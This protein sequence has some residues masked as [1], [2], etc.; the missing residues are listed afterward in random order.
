MFLEQG[1][2][3]SIVQEPVIVIFQLIQHSYKPVDNISLTPGPHA[4]GIANPF[5]EFGLLDH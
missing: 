2:D 5:H 4:M 3:P 1:N